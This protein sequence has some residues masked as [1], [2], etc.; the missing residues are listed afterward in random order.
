[1]SWISPR[2]GS[3]CGCVLRRATPCCL[4]QSRIA[5]RLGSSS[6]TPELLQE[7]RM[8]SQTV[9]MSSSEPDV[10]A[11]LVYDFTWPTG[12]GAPNRTP[13]AASRESVPAA[14]CAAGVD[15]QST[16]Y[17]SRPPRDT[18]S[19]GP[20]S[21]PV[22]HHQREDGTSRAGHQNAGRRDRVFGPDDGRGVRSY[23]VN[24]EAQTEPEAHRS[25]EPPPQHDRVMHECDELADGAHGS[26]LR[27]C[28]RVS[29]HG[30][31]RAG[32]LSPCGA[33]QSARGVRCERPSRP[34]CMLGVAWL[35]SRLLG[36]TMRVCSTQAAQ[37]GDSS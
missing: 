29:S 4:A 21:A 7:E 30:P 22:D 1:M 18:A 33:H 16:A 9:R 32:A 26:R 35:W 14:P 8:V 19:T 37:C 10:T 23:G 24:G 17:R 5:V 27:G 34:G 13:A 3:G 11:P 15:P 25:V 28:E 6:P 36:C 20:R 12:S 31:G 2:S